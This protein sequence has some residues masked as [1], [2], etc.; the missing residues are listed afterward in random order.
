MGT[1]CKSHHKCQADFLGPS[2]SKSQ[3]C[4]CVAL[5]VNQTWL[6]WRF[7]LPSGEFCLSLA[8]KLLKG[9]SSSAS[10][11]NLAQLESPDSRAV[12]DIL[13]GSDEPVGMAGVGC[14]LS[15]E[16]PVHRGRHQ[17]RTGGPALC[18]EAGRTWACEKGSEQHLPTVSDILS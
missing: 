18:E 14:Q 2:D 12:A 9:M 10:T 3:E 16:G 17:P 11:V 8:T 13:S 4:P 1:T 7:A 15:S 6:E 5:T